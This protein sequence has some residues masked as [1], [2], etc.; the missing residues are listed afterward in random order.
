MEF[1]SKLGGMAPVCDGAGSYF[2]Q[3]QSLVI[4]V[5]WPS[6][7]VISCNKFGQNS[8]MLV[9]SQPLEALRRSEMWPQRVS[10]HVIPLYGGVSK[11]NRMPCTLS[12]RS[13]KAVT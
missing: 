9:V 11:S 3:E 4:F 7:L 8:C 6:A 13:M 12:S 5:M 1:L 10:G 2:A